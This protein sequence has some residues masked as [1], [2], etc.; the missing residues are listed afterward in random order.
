MQM[1]IRTTT[2]TPARTVWHFAMLVAMIMLAIALPR[3][4]SAQSANATLR[5][6]AP[7]STEVVATNIATGLTRRVQSSADGTYVLVGL[8][9]VDYKVNEGAGTERAV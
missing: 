4:A 9:P 3:L 8:P 5:G 6:K 2:S 1:N 7:A